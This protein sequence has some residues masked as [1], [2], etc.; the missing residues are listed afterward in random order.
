VFPEQLEQ[1]VEPSDTYWG[2][3][4]TGDVRLLASEQHLDLARH[5]NEHGGI[6]THRWNDQVHFPRAAALLAPKVRDEQADTGW[7]VNT[8]LMPM[9]GWECHSVGCGDAAHGKLYIHLHNTNENQDVWDRCKLD[10]A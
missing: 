2:G 6:Y 7:S 3:W 10:D 8:C 5:L 1:L 4:H 9:F